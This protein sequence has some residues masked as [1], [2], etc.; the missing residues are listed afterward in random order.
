MFDSRDVVHS[1]SHHEASERD[2]PDEQYGEGV[3]AMAVVDERGKKGTRIVISS[4]R[5]EVETFDKQ[6]SPKDKR[7]SNRFSRFFPKRKGKTNRERMPMKTVDEEVADEE[8]SR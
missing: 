1:Q 6:M 7:G 5:K 2:R 4:Q 8:L 3:E